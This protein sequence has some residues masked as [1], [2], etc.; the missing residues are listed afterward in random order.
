LFKANK[1]ALEKAQ[2]VTIIRKGDIIESVKPAKN[3]LRTNVKITDS[4]K[5][6]PE[7][8]KKHVYSFVGNQ[9]DVSYSH[10]VVIFLD[11]HLECQ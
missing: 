1:K 2:N 3:K 4:N 6:D 10:L 7:D 11:H 5:F 8:L 9:E